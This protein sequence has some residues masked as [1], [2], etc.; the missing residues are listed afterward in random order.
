MKRK[1][2]MKTLRYLIVLTIFIIQFGFA[3]AQTDEELGLHSEGGP[4]KF[5]PAPEKND[6]LK[7]VLLIGDSVMNGFR[8]FVTDS[9]RKTANVD[10]WLTP[11]H[12]KSEHL[13]SD[14]QKVV[15]S[16]QYD[17]IQFNIGLHGWPKGRIKDNEYVPLIEKYV[18]TLIENAK[19]AKLIWASITPVTEQD[20]AEL[21]KEINPTI[22]QRNEWA[23]GVM[24]KYNIPVNDLYGL[25]ADKLHLAKLD[26]FHWKP[27]GYQ[28][29]ANQSIKF[30][31]QE[32]NKK[33]SITTL[34]DCNVIWHSPSKNS[35]GSMPAGN[36]DIG[37]NLWVEE[38]G[39]LL[40]YLSKTDAWSENARLLKP[41][42]VRLSLSPNP[43]KTGEPFLQE[44]ILKDGV[45]HIEAGKPGEKV[46]ID[47]W[48]DANHPVVE[49]DVKSQQ[50]ITASVTTEP[51]RVEQREIADNAEIH[52]AYGLKSVVVEK[53]TILEN[54]KENVI[55]AH[56]NERSIWKDNLKMQ[57]L[58]GYIKKGKD[59]LLHNTFGG[60]IY[61]D[62]LHKT[63][64][65]KLETEDAI[66]QFSVSVFA[67]TAQTRSLD[68][69]EKE[70]S[71]IARRVNLE[72]R[73]KRWM[74]HTDW[75]HSFWDRSHIFVSTQNEQEK[76]K[77]ANVTKNYNLQRYINACA[78][79]GNFPIKFNGSIFTVD[80]KSLDNR[81]AGFDA[82]YRQWGG[83]YWW[84][85][86]RLPYWSMLEAGDFDLMQPLLKMYHDIL[87]IRKFATKTYYGH[88]GAFY[89]ET[90][91]HWGTFAEA[92][93]GF[94]RTADMPLGKTV[95][96]FIRYYWQSGLEFSLM[97]LDFYAFTKDEKTLKELILPVVTEVITFFDQHW[98]RDDN[99][100][101]LFEPAMALETYQIAVNPLP[102]IVGINKV[103][104]ELLKLPETAISVE[105]RIQYKRLITEL[106]EIPTREVDGEKLLAPA[107]EYSG[108]QN[109]ENP[110]LYAIFPYRIYSLGK[111]N[112]E[113]AIRTFN[114]RES[115]ENRGWQQHSIKAAYLGLAEEAAKLMAEYF[116]AGTTVYRFPTMWGPNYDWTPD[117][118]HG[119]VAMTAL[120]RML[121]QYEGD[122]IYLFPAWPTDWDV[123]FKLHAPKNTTVEGTV[124]NG[125]I[126]RL[127]VT[128]EER[129]ND[130]VNRFNQ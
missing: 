77:V 60:L 121:L 123:D 128:P 88:E 14:L 52:S 56:R 34:D 53:D 27:E 129:K 30:I 45:I 18:K 81:Y 43:F 130:I 75:W 54:D 101:I 32:I 109:I 73:E 40:L 37:I 9:L 120:Q 92:N 71:Q 36:G 98:G 126:V 82:D 39:D 118:C 86:T 89:I 23:A 11:K 59:P 102:E 69:W 97:A 12:L 108:K 63:T 87:G 57:G 62:Q 78:G 24:K 104:T 93:Y 99:G 49:L 119:S 72:S 74:A 5:Y 79:R 7:N 114:A 61:S 76:E 96:T 58:E 80:T 6:S 127:K 83:P 3:Y 28:L 1:N 31:A 55:W 106:P 20:K 17:V 66:T 15:S 103:C 94:D 42:K 84:Q 68:Q 19:G 47:V 116:N 113:L 41:G 95:N 48:V 70:I 91:R 107:H 33:T 111:D 22:T 125:E 105:Q 8:Q 21:N 29:M 65:K 112:L 110:E 124:K 10:C 117:Q 16:N 122:E 85:N 67:L 64:P 44:L 90:M 13:F 115:I 50:M 35:L 4:W 38:N 100:K 51:W 26:R 2:D 25:V 46:S